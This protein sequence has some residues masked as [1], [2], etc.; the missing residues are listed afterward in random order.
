MRF[1]RLTQSIFLDQFLF[2]QMV[3]VLIGL[4]FP[5]FLV[6]YGFP[7]EEVL[8]WDF[9]IVTQ[10]AGQMV[11]LVSFLLISMVIRPHLK[12]LSHKMQDIAEGLESKSFSADMSR[13]H[14]SLCEIQVES[15]DEI[16]VSANAYNQ[17]LSALI[18]A[19]DV[20]RVF[21]KFSIVMSETL[22]TET[23]AGETINLLIESTHIEGAAI[24]LL[25]RG[26][27]KLIGSQAILNGESLAE[28]DQVMKALKNAKPSHIVLPKNIELDGVIASF[29]PSEVYIEP[30]EF[31]NS[32][33][34]VLVAATGALPSDDRTEQLVHLF[35]RTI[36]LAFNNTIIH[37]KFQKLAAIDGLTNIY[38]RRFGMDRLKE[39]FSRAER[40]QSS[41]S[42][43]MVD[44]DHFKKINDTYGH[45]VGD[46]AIVLIAQI[47][48][49]ALRDGDIVVRYGG[50]EFL[51]I[52]HGASCQ[53]ATAICER[54]R[55]QVL[56]SLI[57]EGEQE[58]KMSVSIG[59]VSYPAVA[60]SNEV[61]LID[62]ADQC[63]YHAKQTGRNKVVPFEIMNFKG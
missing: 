59:L 33:L 37:S 6:W 2:M 25:S 60:A 1:P 54:I 15:K 31:K 8:H 34:G 19:H 53:N 47:L 29:K 32:Q 36:G 35:S 13:C 57:R 46:K 7:A 56:D 49:K 4:S 48:K 16:G 11:G 43:A 58:I 14:E 30:I 23:L 5:Y 38:N 3:G 62:K 63:L 12:L 51:M 45:L 28:H 40:D 42:L 24:L 17:M 50:E 18:Q 52:L 26:E 41:L 21:N 22:E 39:D 44:I 27:L 9:F 61:E 10:I 20:E 55:H